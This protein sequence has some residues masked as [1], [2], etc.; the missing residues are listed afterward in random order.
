MMCTVRINDVIKESVTDGPGLRYVIFAQGCPHRCPGCHNPQTHDFSGGRDV[1]INALLDDIKKNPLLSGVTFSGGEPF[2]QCGPLSKLAALIRQEG[3]DVMV[4][5]G[6]TLEELYLR[7][8]N[9]P[10]ILALLKHADILVD[11]PF[12]IKERDLDLTYRGSR[13]QRIFKKTT[14]GNYAAFVLC[15]Q[16]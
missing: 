15:D 12:L 1:D 14:Q 16:I 7:A 13:N 5:T 3:L 4:Y 11:G 8:D 2:C 6:W 9:Q 10:D